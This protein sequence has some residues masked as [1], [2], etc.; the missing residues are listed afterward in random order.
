MSIN[1]VVIDTSVLIEFVITPGGP[2]G[3]LIRLIDEHGI[4]MLFSAETI[5]ELYEVVFRPKF[6]GYVSRDLRSEIVSSLV[7]LSTVQID[8]LV[9][10][11]RDPSDDKF[12]ETAVN[13]NADAVVSRDKDLLDMTKVAGIP[14][15]SPVDI[16][17]LIRD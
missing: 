17:N 14:I 16:L 3:E 4:D 9:M 2:S 11:C 5:N 1:R 15:L 6:D 8:G 7:P 13:G 12:L 10:G